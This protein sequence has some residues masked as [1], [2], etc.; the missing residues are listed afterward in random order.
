MNL[1]KYKQ[2]FLKFNDKVNN[3]VYRRETIEFLHIGKNG[4][5]AIMNLMRQI[6]AECKEPY[7]FN[8][9]N[10]SIN[11]ADIPLNHRYFFSVR[12][13]LSRFSS[14]FY[15]RKRKGQPRIYREWRP[16]EEVA[17]S[18]F[19]HAN[20]L[21]ESLFSEG[22][23]GLKAFSAMRS[24]SHLKKFQYNWFNQIDYMFYE[25][26]PIYILR[27]ESLS[28]DIDILMSKLG[29]STDLDLTSDPLH[30][31]KTDYSA[32]PALSEQAKKNLE[33]WYE[34]DLFFVNT[35]NKWCDENA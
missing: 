20:D 35:V 6:N 3:I 23:I 8:K 32:I 7:F 16:E 12:S 29:I 19:E 33:K 21:A 1:K 2:Q 28:S 34:A 30:A 17:F 9:N 25:R 31:H 13:P 24:I 4:G 22:D 11:L 18:N 27:Q 15:S 14:A 10:H 5:T 26:P